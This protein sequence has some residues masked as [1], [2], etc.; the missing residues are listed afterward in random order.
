[1]SF[2]LAAKR[3]C[4]DKFRWQLNSSAKLSCVSG[5]SRLRLAVSIATV[6]LRSLWQGTPKFNGA[7]TTELEMYVGRTRGRTDASSK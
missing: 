3:S 4:P 6:Y 7:I 5:R 1:M 2:W